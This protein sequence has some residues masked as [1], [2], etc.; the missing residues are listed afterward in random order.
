MKRSKNLKEKFIR[1]SRRNK[2][3]TSSCFFGLGFFLLFLLLLFGGDDFSADTSSS[4]VL[5]Y[6]IAFRR[7]V[8]MGGC[9]LIPAS[10]IQSEY[11]LEESL[12]IVDGVRENTNI[13]PSCQYF[14]MLNSLRQ[15][16]AD[17]DCC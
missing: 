5:Q 16:S 7:E 17:I 11:L 4:E 10:A 1:V 2:L 15:I 9:R 6:L 14:I 3:Y 13:E 12:S 8:R